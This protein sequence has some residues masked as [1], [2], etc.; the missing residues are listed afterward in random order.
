[1]HPYFFLSHSFI[2]FRFVKRK[3]HKGNSQDKFHHTV[4][5]LSLDLV[6]ERCLLVILQLLMEQLVVGGR[7]TASS[8]FSSKFEVQVP[9]PPFNV[10]IVPLNTKTVPPNTDRIVPPT[11]PQGGNTE[12]SSSKDKTSEPGYSQVK[13]QME[14]IEEKICIIEGSNSHENVNF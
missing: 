2:L 6:L 12:T 1:M 5:L 11:G 4:I 3:S 10:E 14:I 9:P 13:S 7:H 8:P